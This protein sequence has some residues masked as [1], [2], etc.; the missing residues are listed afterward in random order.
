[1]LPFV[2]GRAVLDAV[3]V[4]HMKE[5]IRSDLMK[6]RFFLMT[7]AVGCVLGI[8]LNTT[9]G[10]GTAFT[11][12]GRL[13]D[14]NQAANGTYDLAFSLYLA[15]SGGSPVAGPATNLTVG[16]TNGLFTVQ[17]DF[18]SAPFAMGARWLEMA[19][20][21]NGAGAFTTL[22]P[23]QPLTPVPYAMIAAGLSGPLPATQFGGTYG[24]AIT[25]NNPANNFSGNGYGLTNVNATT[26]GGLG[27]G[28]FW[29]VNGNAGTT[30]GLNYLGTADNQPLEF[31][32][33]GVR[34]LRL[35]PTASGAPNQ[36]G[37]APANFVDDGIA[38]AMIAGGGAMNYGGQIFTNEVA[39]DFGM[40]GGGGNNS[41]WPQSSWGMVGGGSGNVVGGAYSAIAGG[42]SNFTGGVE[43]FIGGGFSNQIDTYTR[44]GMYSRPNAIGSA[45]GGG[46]GNSIQEGNSFYLGFHLLVPSGLNTVGGGGNNAIE[47]GGALAW[48]YGDSILGGLNNGVFGNSKGHVIGG[49]YGNEMGFPNSSASWC[50]IGGGYQNLIEGGQSYS[51]CT[52]GGGSQNVIGQASSYFAACT[53]A[54][55]ENNYADGFD[56]TIAG[57]G[58][59]YIQGP[60]FG[61][62]GSAIGGGESNEVD[63]ADWA[64]IGGGLANMASGSF[65][66]IPG[67]NSNV[68]GADFA[69][70]AGNQANAVHPGA[71]VWGDSTPAPIYSGAS[72]QFTVRASGG[73]RL[74]SN[75]GATA[76]VTLAPGSGSWTSLS[77]KNA[78][79]NFIP[80]NADGVLAKLAALPIST[81]NYKSQDAAIRHIGPTA[82]DFKAAFA[83]GETDTGIATVDEGG[84]ALAAIQG[85]NQKLEEKESEIQA[86]RQNVA[87]LKKLVQELANKK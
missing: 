47:A 58:A 5:L 13:E 1:M 42:F 39:A 17:L 70:A 24:N 52:I 23:R 30:P 10:Q 67:G 69:F 76:G 20:R 19:V 7:W 26:L 86:L 28:S 75:P 62:R 4:E 50:V 87:E 11:Y 56:Q 72:D 82:Q 18:G 74:F 80:V 34:A 40:I 60:P 35:E 32:V 71:F 38:G 81:W 79:E 49:G 45:I 27:A 29:K 85:L 66:T 44:E 59:N 12:Q 41:I 64:T 36:I 51:H 53:I 61:F 22:L 77:D 3:S 2:A 73:V 16:V 25:L 55:G 65:A 8:G 78:K 9:R 84:V 46:S 83:V 37:G 6:F 48:A 31:R 14:N 15:N 33:N 68:A 43:T 57:G 63:S 54:G 21:T